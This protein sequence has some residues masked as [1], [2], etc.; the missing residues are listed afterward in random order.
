MYAVYY[1]GFGNLDTASGTL[2]LALGTKGTILSAV[3]PL[4]WP[5]ERDWFGVLNSST[6]ILY[7]GTGYH[8]IGTGAFISMLRTLLPVKL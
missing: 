6:T 1:M 3:K 7:I 4:S 2:L 8:D 5:L